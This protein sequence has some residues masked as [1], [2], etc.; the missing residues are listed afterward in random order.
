MIWRHVKYGRMAVA[1]LVIAGAPLV[2]LAYREGRALADSE[3]APAPSADAA[4]KQCLDHMKFLALGMLMYV[5]DYD[6]LFPP[7]D[8][9]CDVTLPYLKDGKT[10]HCPADTAEFSYAMNHKLSR[11]RLSH[12][13]DPAGTVLLYESATGR[14]NECDQHGRPG[15]SVPKPPRHGGGNVFAFVDGH[16]KWYRPESVSFDWYR[17]VKEEGPGPA[18]PYETKA[19]EGSK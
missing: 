15:D 16:A 7:A 12:L 10:Y 6:E 4:R 18:R 11:L 9:W 2:W 19:E 14:K 13:E 3:P 1:A 5:R 17:V 8:R